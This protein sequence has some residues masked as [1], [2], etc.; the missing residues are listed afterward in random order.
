MKV[1]LISGKAQHGKDTSAIFMKEALELEGRRVLI[2]H[3]GD[4][5]KFICEKYFG[6]DG[7]KDEKGRSLLQYVGTDVVRKQKPD[8]W[9]NFV[10]EVLEMFSD[11]WDRVIIPDCRFPNT[12]PWPRICRSTVA[13]SKPSLVRAIAARR[14]SPSSVVG[15]AISTQVPGWRPRPT[16]PRS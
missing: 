12:V 11:Q 9:V 8:F 14:S 4:L 10:C 5:V 13:S 7:K 6:W 15:S 1:I 3:Y 16:R 2:A